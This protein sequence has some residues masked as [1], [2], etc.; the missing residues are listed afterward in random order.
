MSNR[1]P[2]TEELRSP[3]GERRNPPFFSRSSKSVDWMVSL[4]IRFSTSRSDDAVPDSSTRSHARDGRSSWADEE[5]DDWVET[6]GF[7][8]PLIS[9]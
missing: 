2:S 9:R 3:S 6:S 5:A 1:S 8:E 4:L 7:D